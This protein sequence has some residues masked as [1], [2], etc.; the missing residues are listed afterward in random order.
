VRRNIRL[1]VSYDG[2]D[3]AGWQVQ[4]RDR[5]VQ[6]ILEE[7]L[8]DL[9]GHPVSLTGA[10]RTDSGV[11]ALGQVANFF[12]EKD[13]V[14]PWKFRDAVNSRLP[15]DVRV[16]RSD[17]V[18][19]EFHSRRDAVARHYE[20][21]IIPGSV[22]PA[23]LARFAWLVKSMPSLRRLNDMASVLCGSHDFTT[24]AAAGDGSSSR[25]RRI[26]HA[27]FLAEGPLVTFR[28]RGNAF[29]WRMVRSILGTLIDSARRG[30]D[31]LE[32][33]S[34]LDARDRNSAGPT[35]PP[36]GLFLTKVEYGPISG[37][38]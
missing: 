34:I 30:G 29:L 17:E 25:I 22:G 19:L 4:S 18:P 33:R 28:I 14:P 32:M 12:T 2:T 27:V 37:L 9:H 23:P 8:D 15:R 13:S 10:G 20:Y 35:A 11:H 26:D 5:S 21:R 31:E 24:F 38:R 7:A 36:R 16:L 1:L 3:F 6:G